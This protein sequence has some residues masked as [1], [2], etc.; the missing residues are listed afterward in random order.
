MYACMHVCMH[1]GMYARMYACMH[2][3]MHDIFVVFQAHAKRAGPLEPQK[4]HGSSISEKTANN[5]RKTFNFNASRAHAA[6][7]PCPL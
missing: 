4:V 1:V 5:E 3:C 6:Q 2:A 7:G